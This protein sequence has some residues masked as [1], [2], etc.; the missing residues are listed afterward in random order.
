MKL[1]NKL[2]V[3]AF[4]N[5]VNEC[6]GNVFLR[7]LQGDVFNLKSSLSQYI[8][9]GALLGEHGDELELFAEEKEDEYKLLDFVNKLNKGEIDL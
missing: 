5:A 8:A 4:I 9:M 1:K 3:N 2:E 7:S 6:E